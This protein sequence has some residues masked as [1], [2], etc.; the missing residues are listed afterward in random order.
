MNLFFFAFSTICY[1]YISWLWIIFFVLYF[2][3]SF[4]SFH[5][6]VAFVFYFDG[7][8][9]LCFLLLINYLISFFGSIWFDYQLSRGFFFFFFFNSRDTNFTPEFYNM[10]PQY[11]FSSFPSL[12]FSQ[13]NFGTWLLKDFFFSILNFLP[14]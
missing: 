6:I 7:E 9:V 4:L 13:M 14:F 3:F 12:K 5:L 2:Y 10:R 1:C 11:V 8:L